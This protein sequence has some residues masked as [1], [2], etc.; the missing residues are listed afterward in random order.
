MHFWPHVGK[1]KMCFKTIQSFLSS[2]FLAFSHKNGL[3][4]PVLLLKRCVFDP[5]MLVKPTCV[6]EIESDMPYPK[7]ARAKVYHPT[8]FGDCAVIYKALLA[9]PS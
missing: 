5:I 7:N 6:W 3:G 9:P 4:N 8:P 1:A 2:Q